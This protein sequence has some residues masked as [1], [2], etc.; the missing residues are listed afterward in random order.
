MFGFRSQRAEKAAAEPLLT[1]KSA[2]AWLRQLPAVDL[3][4]RQQQ[5]AVAIDGMCRSGRDI[6][7]DRVGAIEYLD[8]EL[9]ADRGRLIGQY[10]EHATS[11]PTVADRVWQ[12]AYAAIN[13]LIVAYRTLLET[14]TRRESE[15]RW[16]RTR[17]R[18]I[19]RLIHFLGTDARLRALKNE[20]WIP[21][22]WAELHGLYQ[23]AVALAVA[24]EPLPPSPAGQIP[25]PLT[26]EQEY[27]LVLLTHQLNTGTLAPAD[28]DWAGTQ[29][30]LWVGALTLETVPRTASGF[31]VD[32]GG[33]AG[34]VRRSRAEAGALLRYLDTLPLAEELERGIAALRRQAMSDIDAAGPAT[35][36]RIAVL[37]RLRP[38]LSP[39][40]PSA[41]SRDPREAVSIAAQ[42]RMGLP[43]ICQE[44]APSD[45]R[46]PAIE[47]VNGP[48]AERE[49][50]GVTVPPAGRD[51]IAVTKPHFGE[52]L[53]RI[54]D[55]SATGMRIVA[56]AGLGEGLGLGGLVMVRPPGDPEWIL[57]AVR[58]MTKA[59]SEKV[60][61]GVAILSTRFMAVTLHAKRQ[62]R[63]DMGFIVDGVDVSTMGKRF[64]GLYLA[65]PS[66]P[67]RPLNVKSLIVPTSEYGD[68][69]QLF[70]ITG[71]SVYTVALREIHEGQPDWTWAT[72]EIVGKTARS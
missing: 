62:A 20:R 49:A 21:A 9:A 42:V 4:G 39:E 6:E 60:D 55:R 48:D 71:N 57:G 29:L 58:R 12:A 30:R 25:T 63:E 16:R 50:K 13:A 24:R 44:L 37:E 54:E 56:G 69:R 23:Q 3:I 1:Q 14:A 68:G 67:E 26:I 8:A 31:V 15:S 66:R 28:I 70:L 34:L 65:P 2:S 45:L 61:A 43:R 38:V 64:E 18:L 35:A 53:W 22:K 10:V 46:N 41:V 52:R 17:P 27:L 32:L 51:P 47:G 72:I 5:V 40:A 59:T 19:A 33:K 11:N 7:F 36:Q